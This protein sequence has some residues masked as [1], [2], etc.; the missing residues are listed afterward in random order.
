MTTFVSF[1]FDD[2]WASWHQATSMLESHGMRGTFYLTTSF[3]PGNVGGWNILHGWAD[4]GH[5]IGAHTRNHWYVDVRANAYDDIMFGLQDMQANGFNTPIGGFVPGSPRNVETFAYT[6]FQFT[7]ETAQLLDHIGFIAG[8]GGGGAFD[9]LPPRDGSNYMVRSWD[10]GKM[11]TLGDPPGWAWGLFRQSVMDAETYSTQHG[12]DT[13]VDFTLHEIGSN[14]VPMQTD[15][16]RWGDFL[17]WLEA[18]QP[19]TQVRTFAEV[20]RS[21]AKHSPVRYSSNRGQWTGQ[22]GETS[23]IFATNQVQIGPGTIGVEFDVDKPSFLTAYFFPNH[24]DTWGNIILPMTFALYEVRGPAVGRLVPDSTI[25]FANR[26]GAYASG[27]FVWQRVPIHVPLIPGR[28]YRACVYGPGDVVPPP[29]GP[30]GVGWWGE[31]PNAY[32]DSVRMPG[33]ISAL[34][35]DRLTA[36]GQ[37]TWHAGGSSL[38]YPTVSLNNSSRGIDVEVS[39]QVDGFEAMAIAS[40]VHEDISGIDAV[41]LH[42]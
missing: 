17:G 23:G 1:T 19:G 37:N 29:T 22:S 40:F 36:G 35:S 42:S 8:R 13:H 14:R 34:A 39:E 9:T 33:G 28:R 10:M 11:D 24:W 4:N 16:G 5:E 18:R 15:P 12:I 32:T 41:R 7:A 26:L 3:G 31:T 30:I 21:H 6:F 25:T 27:T 38:T 20:M 2:G